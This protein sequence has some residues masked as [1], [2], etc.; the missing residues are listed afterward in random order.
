M[1][2]PI[3][4]RIVL[5]GA[6]EIS[7]LLK[8]ITGDV[9][10][11][12]VASKDL[13][14]DLSGAGFDTLK[15]QIDAATSGNDKAKT[16]FKGLGVAITD[17]TGK[18]RPFNDI[19]RDVATNFR[20]LPPGL[21]QAAAN[22]RLFGGESENVLRV[23]SAAPA[24]ADDA[25]VG[26]EK[27]A[28]S[29]TRASG[30]IASIGVAIGG[31]AAFAGIIALG[32]AL[33]D[34]AKGSAE[35][36]DRIK[37][38][39]DSAQVS[40]GEVQR[41]RAVAKAAGL[42]V[43][44][45]DSLLQ[46]MRTTQAQLARDLKSQLGAELER[47]GGAVRSLGKS[48]KDAAASFAEPTVSVR[49]FG[50][51][52]KKAATEGKGF[53]ELLKRLSIPAKEFE[54]LDLPAQFNRI[55][56]ALNK[57]PSGNEKL[58]IQQEVFKQYPELQKMFDQTA[59]AREDADKR[60]AASGRAQTEAEIARGLALKESLDKAKAESTGLGDAIQATFDK[61]GSAISPQVKTAVDAQS[62]AFRFLAEAVDR[63]RPSIVSF[64][65]E[66]NRALTELDATGPK[67]RAAISILGDEISKFDWSGK[68]ESFKKAATDAYTFIVAE[69]RTLGTDIGAAIEAGFKKSLDFIKAEWNAWVEDLKK[70]AQTVA[71][72]FK[73]PE[74]GP[75]QGS[76]PALGGGFG[77]PLLGNQRPGFSAD[78][79]RMSEN[80][81]DRRGENPF[82]P[83]EE[84]AQGTADAIAEIFRA[85]FANIKPVIV[86]DE[87]VASAERAVAQITETFAAGVQT[88]TAAFASADWSGLERGPAEAATNILATFQEL[89]ARITELFGSGLPNAV[90]S[91][92]SGIEGVVAGMV[93]NVSAQLDEL[94]QKI[95][96]VA[97]AAANVGGG[98]EFDFSGPI[99]GE[100]FARGGPVR[101]PGSGKS[102]SIL[103][104]LSNGEFVLKA[105][106]V[107]KWGVGFLQS[108]NQG[109]MPRFAA[110]GHVSMPKFAGLPRFAAGGLA[111]LPSLGGSTAGM[112]PANI[113]L[114]GGGGSFPVMAQ[115][116][117][118]A[119][120]ARAATSQKLTRA[121]R[122]ASWET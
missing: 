36:A 20:A 75:A 17:A 47:T 44:E 101:G 122:R 85:M 121:G 110:G 25:G 48:N 108:L 9:K 7:T 52:Q 103:A 27:I 21:E 35:A 34:L 33:F 67:G 91:A 79:F 42:S 3:K 111:A 51:E 46:R 107:R 80:V 95:Q 29:A 5:E 119:S 93:R 71:D 23:L 115:P 59:K 62:E 61:I 120:L 116:D 118:L 82:L 102:D 22:M 69:A 88:A 63:A 94:A 113:N 92:M 64:F 76:D 58:L 4:Q 14:K 53:E 37:K 97:E 39:S 70:I 105:D 1:A 81:E 96:E 28:V 43:E 66:W 117:V 19:A 57:L 16:A 54:K 77:V 98:D 56:D 114:P 31:I 40:T 26:F 8:G 86:W 90:Q 30:A 6:E 106:A 89:V 55:Q 38:V 60:H 24:L 45:A 10:D 41:F 49:R 104:W 100:G 2:Q 99:D 13:N 73:A 74:Q 84:Q 18:V 32:K 109:R 50:E 65:E 12:G 11:L 83:M 87:L 72:L 112:V 15:K 68:W 78:G